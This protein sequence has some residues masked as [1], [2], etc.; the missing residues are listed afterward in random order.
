MSVERVFL[1]G[2]MGSGKSTVGRMLSSAMDWD[3]IDLDD[4]IQ[5]RNGKTITEIFKTEGEAVF[6]EM[7][8]NALEDMSLRSNLIIATGGGTPCFHN[9]LDTMNRIGLT[10]YL[11]LSP[12]ELCE[13]L[14]PA[15]KSR[16]LIADKS[17]RELL[18]FVVEK[19]SERE[20]WYKKAA[21]VA[22]A[23]AVGPGSYLNIIRMFE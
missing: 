16:P 4:Y 9:N 18:K 11:K 1:I 21:V 6:R 8:R 12:E 17:E 5:E 14:M 7:E 20:Q 19:L 10:I 22:D 13:R 15:R 2:F 23:R 3:F